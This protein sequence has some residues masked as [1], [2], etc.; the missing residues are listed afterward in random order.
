MAM[1]L[2]VEIHFDT[3]FSLSEHCEDW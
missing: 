2:R 1:E 3:K